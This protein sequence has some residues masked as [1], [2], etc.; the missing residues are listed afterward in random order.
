MTFNTLA[1]KGHGQ[2]N[3]FLT[4]QRDPNHQY[5]VDHQIFF[6][7]IS[8]VSFFMFTFFLFLIGQSTRNF[9]VKTESKQNLVK[10]IFGDHQIFWWFGSREHVINLVT[11]TFQ[12]IDI[13]YSLNFN[14]VK[15]ENTLS[16]R[17]LNKVLCMI[18]GMWA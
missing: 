8:A 14:F 9:S 13:D 5:L 3:R 16:F 6:N 1:Q 15:H 2:R 10:Q 11:H 17:Q 12:K 18:C 7:Q 4:C